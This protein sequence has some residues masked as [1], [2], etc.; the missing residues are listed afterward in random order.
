M[1]GLAMAHVFD[2]FNRW[3]GDGP[4]QALRVARKYATQA[5]ATDPNEPFAHLA[6]SRIAMY[7]KNLDLA[8][9]EAAK[10]LA[11]NPNFALAH[12]TLGSIEIYLGHPL[13]AVPLI[14]RAMR[15]DPAFTQ[16]YLHF[17]GCAYLVA[18]KYETAA[19]IFKQRVLLVPE[20]DLSRGFLA[21]ALGQLGQ[22]DEARQVWAELMQLNPRYSFADHVGRLPFSN[23][24]DVERIAAGLTKAGL[25]A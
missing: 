3:S 8:Q 19:V 2:Y 22:K 18:G 14:E 6:L 12:H 16:Q 7:E 5:I 9:A 23:P 4:D 25:P 20:T 17:L 10:A 11:L 1:A 24:E 21:A 13:A 15:L